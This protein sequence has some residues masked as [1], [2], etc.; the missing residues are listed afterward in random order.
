MY[1]FSDF[2]SCGGKIHHKREW[3]SYIN[4]VP[5]HIATCQIL[6]CSV[7]RLILSEMDGQYRKN[8]EI[9]DTR[10]FAVITL[11][12]EQDGFSLE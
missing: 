11:K 9:L 7:F 10:K 3:M 6:G 4:Q 12:I 5:P 1:S 8:P 2:L